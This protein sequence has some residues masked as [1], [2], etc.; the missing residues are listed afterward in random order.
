MDPRIARRL[1]LG[2]GGAFV[3]LLLIGAWATHGWLW[4]IHIP[5]YSQF[6]DSIPTPPTILPETVERD[7]QPEHPCGRSTY[8]T[9]SEHSEAVDF[10]LEQLPYLGWNLVEHNAWRGEL[11]E[12]P[13][14]YTQSDI[15]LFANRRWPYWLVVRI[16]TSVD[17]GAAHI[18]N[19]GITL[20]ICRN[21][22][23]SSVY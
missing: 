5:I 14:E 22:E 17:A 9:N 23:L 3:L 16:H 11:K 7:L 19:P 6:L 2:F 1:V 10:F 20:S 18:G 12:Q 4:S 13:G 21:K 15:M 8:E